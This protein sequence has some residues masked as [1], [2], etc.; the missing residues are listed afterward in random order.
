MAQNLVPS[1]NL[2]NVRVKLH[3]LVI[4]TIDIKVVLIKHSCYFILFRWFYFTNHFLQRIQVE[5]S[6][7]SFVFVVT[8]Y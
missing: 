7:V 5:C 1:A 8:V 2:G 4:T 3:I 6:T